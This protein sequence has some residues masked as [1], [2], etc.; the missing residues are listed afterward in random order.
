MGQNQFFEAFFFGR[1]AH[2]GATHTQ[3]L[4]TRSFC[5]KGKLPVSQGSIYTWSIPADSFLDKE[6]TCPVHGWFS[7]GSP[8]LVERERERERCETY[9][10][11]IL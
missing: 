7:S 4:P 5:D 8:H 1:T 11:Q 2:Q 10:I 9:L 6:E 3:P